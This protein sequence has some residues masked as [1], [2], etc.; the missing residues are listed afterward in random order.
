MATH[1]SLDAKRAARSE[2]ANEPHEVVFG[3]ETFAFPAWMPLEYIDHLDAGRMRMAFALLFGEDPDAD[4]PGGEV[5]ARFFSH[6]PDNGD[7]REISQALYST[8]VGESSASPD[9]SQNGGRPSKPTGKRTTTA[10]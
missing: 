8:N 2:A 9:S 1:L 3:G 10:T 7:L 4:P 5:T 6:R